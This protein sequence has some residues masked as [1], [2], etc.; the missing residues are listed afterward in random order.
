M[1]PTVNLIFS[2]YVHLYRSCECIPIIAGNFPFCLL[3]TIF[4]WRG[5]AE[6]N[7]CPASTIY[8]LCLVCSAIWDERR[9][10]FHCFVMSRLNTEWQRRR[11]PKQSREKP[12]LSGVLIKPEQY[13]KVM[14]KEK[15]FP[16]SLTSLQLGEEHHH[17]LLWL[18]QND[19]FWSSVFHSR[20]IQI[21][22]FFF[23]NVCSSVSLVSM[24]PLVVNDA[25]IAVKSDCFILTQFS[26]PT[27]A[28]CMPP[29]VS[30]NEVHSSA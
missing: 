20:L 14:T 18:I 13:G 27:G 29:H 2:R 26:D 19:M 22:G 11:T 17:A 28:D 5:W 15:R 10:G 3:N 1:A 7:N 25:L 12:W 8:H 6:L 21:A 30:L 4:T 16:Y 24:Q 23:F 9:N